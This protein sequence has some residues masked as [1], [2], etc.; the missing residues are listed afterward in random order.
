MKDN[1]TEK[2]CEICNVVSL[3]ENFKLPGIEFEFLENNPFICEKC[4]YKILINKDI[5]WKYIIEKMLGTAN[6]PKKW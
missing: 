4:L 3:N 6:F 1:S 2:H 5:E